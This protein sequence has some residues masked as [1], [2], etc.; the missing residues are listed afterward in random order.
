[1]NKEGRLGYQKEVTNILK[2]QG[3]RG[4]YRGFWASAWRDVP[5][6]GIFFASYEYLKAKSD[7][8]I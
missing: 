2:D 5:G 7:S 3:V 6:W 8:A 1:V 4:L